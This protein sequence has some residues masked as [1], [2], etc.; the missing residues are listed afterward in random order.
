MEWII[1]SLLIIAFMITGAAYCYCV[2]KEKKSMI[3]VSKVIAFYV[4]DCICYQAACK[5][6]MPTLNSL[7]L[8]VKVIIF[9]SIPMPVLFL[10]FKNKKINQKEQNN[11]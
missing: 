11:E 7:L 3:L 8:A 2:L 10:Y 9:I 4:L 6:I 1:P 5:F